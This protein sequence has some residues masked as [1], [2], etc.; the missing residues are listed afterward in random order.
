ME[1]GREKRLNKLAAGQKYHH[2]HFYKCLKVESG[3]VFRVQEPWAWSQPERLW[4]LEDSPPRRRPLR[5]EKAGVRVNSPQTEASAN[6][7]TSTAPA[8]AHRLWAAQL[9]ACRYQRE[10]NAGNG[11]SVISA[12]GFDNC[13]CSLTGECL[14]LFY[15]KSSHILGILIHINLLEDCESHK[16]STLDCSKWASKIFLWVEGFTGH[17]LCCLQ[18]PN[19]KCLLERIVTVLWHKI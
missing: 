7:V 9:Q 1:G 19:Q 8:P 5:S 16:K 3:F 2:S 10:S 17:T 12:G 18:T 4:P 15:E 11:T 14:L 13:H 6:T